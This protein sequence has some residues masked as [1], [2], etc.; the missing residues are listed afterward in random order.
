MRS[1][2]TK[3]GMSHVRHIGLRE[4]VQERTMWHSHVGT[5]KGMQWVRPYRIGVRL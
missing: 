5:V 2:R 4:G 3:K 1:S